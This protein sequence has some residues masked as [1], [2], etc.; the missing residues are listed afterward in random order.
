[1]EIYTDKDLETFNSE[2]DNVINDIMLVQSNVFEPPR[3]EI[4]KITE[5]VHEFITKY[6][7]K[8][9]GGYAVNFLLKHKNKNDAIYG[10]LQIPDID[11]YSPDPI[12]DLKILCNI[13]YSKGFRNIEGKE[14][15]HKE[16]YSIYVNRQNYVDITYVPKNIFH[17]MP[18]TEVQKMNMTHPHFILIDHYRMLTDP[19]ASYWRIKKTVPRMYKLLH[20]YPLLKLNKPLPDLIKL[21]K[22]QTDKLK[23][24]LDSVGKFLYNKTSLIVIGLGAYNYLLNKSK[25]WKQDKKFTFINVPYYEFISEK[26][27]E[28]VQDLVNM[29]KK[30]YGDDK[31]KIV[32][33]YPFF[34]FYG[35]NVK[36]YYEDMLLFWAC[37]NAQKC[38]S[39]QEVT[40]ISIENNKVTEISNNKIA[41]GSFA[42]IMMMNLI[43]TIY[44]RAS[45]DNSK[46]NLHQIIT[47]H[48]LIMRN[49]YFKTQNMTLMDESIFQEFVT[50]CIGPKINPPREA[51]EEREQKKI[52]RKNKT[53]GSYSFC[54]VPNGINTDE[55]SIH[56]F[57]NSSGN[58]VNKPR[59]LIFTKSSSLLQNSE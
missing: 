33:H 11:F 12:V 40:P 30:T 42:L 27:K 31:I 23:Q 37:D 49:H 44:Y 48:L 52:N 56:R 45:R 13:L 2:I 34:Q 22:P 54:F 51:F 14:A 25:L 5:I 10:D 8:I 4:D 20:H 46:M 59:D 32:E 58:P 18:F 47:S 7:R 35:Y 19:L 43:T 15:Q 57:H 38:L 24:I 16:T 17:R 9:Y 39:C 28:D 26:Y 55:T 3:D 6:K 50:T 53:K 21:W 1:M 29:L 41:I 36:V